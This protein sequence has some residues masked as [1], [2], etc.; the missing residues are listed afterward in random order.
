MG[1][2]DSVNVWVIVLPLTGII[3]VLIF[4]VMC[5]CRY[6]CR[7]ISVISKQCEKRIGSNDTVVKV[8]L[9]SPAHI[10]EVMVSLSPKIEQRSAP[11]GSVSTPCKDVEKL[12]AGGR[13]SS[14][15]VDVE[16]EVL[17]EDNNCD[18]TTLSPTLQVQLVNIPT[19]QEASPQNV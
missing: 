11:T 6:T 1:G 16:T 7:V 13:Q 2:D 4:T 17:L 14:T 8:P 5:I 15:I 3:L 12:P 18:Q 19:M 9:P 10:N